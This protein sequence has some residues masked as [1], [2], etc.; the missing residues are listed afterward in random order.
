MIVESLT[1][2]DR[3]SSLLY[4]LKVIIKEGSELE[5]SLKGIPRVNLAERFTPLKMAEFNASRML[6][7]PNHNFVVVLYKDLENNTAFASHYF[8]EDNS[9]ERIEAEM[10]GNDLVCYNG[11]LINFN[12]EV[13]INGSDVPKHKEYSDKTTRVQ[14]FLVNGNRDCI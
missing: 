6:R 11:R 8:G 4:Q 14:R 13:E 7:G 5:E 3:P 1:C 2:K 9:Y 12:N 10:K